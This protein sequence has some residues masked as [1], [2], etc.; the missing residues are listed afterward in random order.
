MILLYHKIYLESPSIWWVN[1]DNFYR[2]MYDLQNKKVVFLDDYDYSDEDHVVITFDGVYKN[3]LEY[4]AP[5]LQKFKYPFELFVT[6][7]YIGKDNKW[8][9]KEPYTKFADID[10]LKRLTLLGGRLQWHT[11]SH[12][13]M[14][15]LENINQIKDELSVPQYLSEI[16]P[17]GFKWF[18][19]P[20]G[21]YTSKILTEVQKKFKGSLSCD[22]GKNND[23]YRL[24]RLIVTNDSR[25][26]NTTIALIIASFNYGALLVEAI[27]SVLRQTILPDEILITDDCSND[28]TQEIAIDYKKKYPDLIKYNRNDTNLGIVKNF[29]KAVSLTNSDYILFLGADNRLLSN[30]IEETKK[31]LDSSDKIGISYTDFALFGPRAKVVHNLFSENLRG[32]IKKEHFIINFPKWDKHSKESLEKGNFI[33]GSSMYKRQAYDDVGGYQEKTSV[34]EDHDLFLRMVRNGWEARK[35]PSTFLEYRQHSREQTNIR[36]TT[37]SELVFYKEK[38]R[39]LLDEKQRLSRLL[40][41]KILI[42][43]MF[44]E[45]AYSILKKEGFKE[46]RNRGVAFLKR[47]LLG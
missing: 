46:F 3:V 11:K 34:A 44:C 41:Y 27:E 35:A 22:Q 17:K 38:Y 16:D 47:K 15:G 32:E 14:N 31:L 10:D 25:F 5:I 42:P 43:L 8:D 4:A 23:S 45:K 26:N 33:H 28:S 7:N 18:A 9:V 24:K 20:H 21:N 39:E 37:Y 40:I 1:A 13:D 29:N 36:R 12:L 2:Q 6:G 30:Y 19:F